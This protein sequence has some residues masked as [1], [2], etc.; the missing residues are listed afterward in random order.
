MQILCLLV[1]GSH[2][3]KQRIS[4][5]LAEG[6]LLGRLKKVNELMPE[7]LSQHPPP[8]PFQCFLHAPVCTHPPSALVASYISF[9]SL[10]ALKLSLPQGKELS[11][12]TKGF[13]IGSPTLISVFLLV[14]STPQSDGLEGPLPRPLLLLM[15]LIAGGSGF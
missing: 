4:L 12:S 14:L 13:S 2:F 15:S 7:I 6:S 1:G 5:P 3:G 8:Q 9:K 11:L 10:G